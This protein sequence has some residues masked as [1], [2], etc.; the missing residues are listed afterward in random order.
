MVEQSLV[1]PEELYSTILLLPSKDTSALSAWDSRPSIELFFSFDISSLSSL[2]GAD[3]QVHSGSFISISSLV[4]G[5]G[6][7]MTQDSVLPIKCKREKL[8]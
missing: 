1:T 8:L 4:D 2:I 3:S 7:K 5:I 6:G